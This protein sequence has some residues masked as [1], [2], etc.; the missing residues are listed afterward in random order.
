MQHAD[1]EK[2]AEKPQREKKRSKNEGGDKNW[3]GEKQ[4]GEKEMHEKV[5]KQFRNKK[6]K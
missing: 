6:E 2:R 3:A 5:Y 4:K 1:W